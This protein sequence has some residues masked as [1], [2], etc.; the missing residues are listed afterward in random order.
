M[1]LAGGAYSTRQELMRRHSMPHHVVSGYSSVFVC[2]GIQFVYVE[3]FS[4]RSA[5]GGC[6]TPPFA[7]ELFF[8]ACVSVGVY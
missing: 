6:L 3:N 1:L 5:S 4:D 7:P 8:S 2:I